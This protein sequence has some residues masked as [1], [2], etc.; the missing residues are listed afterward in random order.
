MDI[1]EITGF[2]DDDET[3]RRTY[4]AAAALFLS[5]NY[6][7]DE[8]KTVG[9]SYGALRKECLEAIRQWPGCE[10]VSGIQIIRDNSPAGFSVRIT[11]YGEADER[12]ADRTMN[13]IQREKRRH[14]HL[15]E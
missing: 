3:G 15:T 14:F 2:G 12:I 6:C 10:T 1:G 7:D 4:P 13:C 8:I 11:L 5:I 9:V